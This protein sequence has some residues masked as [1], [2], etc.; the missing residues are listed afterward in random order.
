MRIERIKMLSLALAIRFL[1]IIT[2]ARDPTYYF[3]P[4]FGEATRLSGASVVSILD[5]S[6]IEGFV[7]KG[8]RLA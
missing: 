5:D 4:G 6:I 7:V 1:K 2:F 8:L 3:F